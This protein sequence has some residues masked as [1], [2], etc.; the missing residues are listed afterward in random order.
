MKE[1]IST[2]R[3]NL[4]CSNEGLMKNDQLDRYNGKLT[5]D[6][7][8]SKLLKVGT[9]ML[10]TYTITTKRNSSVFE[11]AMK[12]T[13]ITRPYNNDSTLLATPNAHMQHCNPLLDRSIVILNTILNL[14][15]LWQHVCWKLHS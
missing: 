3:L 6:H 8:V 2:F 7:K 11:R 5:L 14:H 4:P 10:F 13:S 15:L 9:N 12:M 1:Q